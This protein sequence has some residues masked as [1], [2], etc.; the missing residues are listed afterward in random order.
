LAARAW[1]GGDLDGAVRFGLADVEIASG[2]EALLAGSPESCSSLFAKSDFGWRESIPTR[3][4]PLP[5]LRA[6]SV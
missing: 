5:R 6:E 2:G 1:W 3:A 4:F